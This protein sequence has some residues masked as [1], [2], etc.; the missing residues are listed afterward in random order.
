[1]RNWLIGRDGVRTPYFVDC[2]RASIRTIPR[3]Q[4]D[5]LKGEDIDTQSVDHVAD[6]TRYACMARPWLKIP[7][8]EAG[9]RRDERVGK[10]LEGLP[11]TDDK[12]HGAIS[13]LLHNQLAIM[14][15]LS[16]REPA[17]SDAAESLDWCITSTLSMLHEDAEAP[18][19]A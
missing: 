15:A 12:L 2:C 19:A 16:K 9:A 11:M 7:N 1:M 8:P 10:I 6:E 14:V 17:D 13:Q 4:H 3:L 5:P 18:P